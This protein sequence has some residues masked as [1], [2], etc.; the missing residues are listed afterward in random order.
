MLAPP[1]RLKILPLLIQNKVWAFLAM[2]FNVQMNI[3]KS[4][5]KLDQPITQYSRVSHLEG[6]DLM[7]GCHFV[8]EAENSQDAFFVQV[9][10][11]LFPYMQFLSTSSAVYTT[12]RS[13]CMQLS[14]NTR[15]WVGKFLWPAMPYSSFRITISTMIELRQANN[16][17]LS[18]NLQSQSN[19]KGGHLLLQ[20]IWHW[21]GC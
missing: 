18:I 12:C 1:Q 6:G 10:L 20:G 14:K 2:R 7:I 19:I 3:V 5:I 4:V 8:K 11:A 16:G 17:H 9:S 21:R 15:I 13:T